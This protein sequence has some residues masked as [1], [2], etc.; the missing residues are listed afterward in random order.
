MP[1]PPVF[2]DHAPVA[3]TEPPQGLRL[4]ACAS[5]PLAEDLTLH[6]ALPARSNNLDLLA[7]ERFDTTSILAVDRTQPL[8]HDRKITRHSVTVTSGCSCRLRIPGWD[9]ELTSAAPWLR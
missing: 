7:A 2:D 4:E 3:A 8:L 1:L 9:T 6:H 5:E